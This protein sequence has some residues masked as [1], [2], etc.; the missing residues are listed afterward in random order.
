MKSCFRHYL[1]KTSNACLQHLQILYSTGIVYLC[2]LFR[3]HVQVIVR[4]DKIFL[5]NCWVQELLWLWLTVEYL[6][7]RILCKQDRQFT[8]NRNSTER[9]RNHCCHEKAI[10]ITYSECFCS[11]PRMQSACAVLYSHL[12]PVLLYD[13][14]PHY[15]TNGTILEK[16]SH[17]MQNVYFYLPYSF[18]WNIS[19]SKKTVSE[20]C[21]K[22]TKAIMYGNRHFSQ[23]LSKMEFYRQNF[24]KI[25][26]YEISWKS[27]Q[28]EQSCSM[29]KDGRADRYNEVNICFSP[30]WESGWKY[31]YIVG[32]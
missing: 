17:W 21:H 14:F 2:K 26:N 20:V 10:L 4:N 31:T 6:C 22:C 19:H 30:F 29:L 13:I 15:L 5:Y 3:C 32:T 8:Y 27:I 16:K 7:W 18:V 28:W 24:W 23:I 25:F 12:W 11:L 1:Y 9:S